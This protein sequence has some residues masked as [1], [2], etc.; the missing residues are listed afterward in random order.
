MRRYLKLQSLNILSGKSLVLEVAQRHGVATN[1]EAYA[2]EIAR[3]SHG[4]PWLI[5]LAVSKLDYM[6]PEAIINELTA[7]QSQDTQA[8][9]NE[10]I[11]VTVEQMTKQYGDKPL[12]LLR[13][14]SVCRG[15]FNAE[16]ALLITDTSN[17]EDL[18][19]HLKK[20]MNYRFLRFDGERYAIDELVSEAVGIDDNARRS[21]YETYLTIAHRW[22]ASKDPEKYLKMDAEWE[23]FNAAFEWVLKV[24]PASAVE[25]ANAC[26]IYLSN[27][28]KWS[29]RQ[30]WFLAL[31]QEMH[32]LD[33]RA[34]ATLHN[35]LGVTY[36]ENPF[37]D[38]RY[39][40]HRA[41]V[42]YN[43]AL[44]YRTPEST[45]LEYASTQNNLGN[46]LANLAEFESE[47]S[48]YLKQAI[49]AF[50]EALLYWTP[51]SDPL[52]HANI[53]NNLGNTY[54][55]LSTIED[56]EI[57]VE[58]AI[59]SYNAALNYFTSEAIPLSRATTQNNLGNTY[60]ILS[61]V[62]DQA[63]N[64]KRSITAYEEALIIRTPENTPFEYAVTQYNLGNV[65]Q[66]LA[67]VEDRTVNF[68]RALT[69][70]EAALL[71]GTMDVAPLQN[72]K[73]KGNLG[74]VLNYLGDLPRAVRYWR[75]AE[76]QFRT[77]GATDDAN[78]L[79]EWIVQ[80]EAVLNENPPPKQ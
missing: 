65:Y 19:I 53:Q 73:T 18:Y 62:R 38:R 70:Y 35:G 56:R 34:K 52:N 8:A 16:S 23:N 5:E 10:I 9:L 26:G 24:D 69:A 48:N 28:G 30:K 54:Q 74:V 40:L 57:N 55:L 47:P 50:D 2:E 31:E 3:A 75:E 44:S 51:E 14:L 17:I 80:G 13:R 64:L 33:P 6:P 68:N 42:E 61:E 1:L 27:R 41:I 4:H 46:A 60:R 12:S 66:I 67:R 20:L 78:R 77:M 29:Q 79:L 71:Y 43:A 11:G 7:L 37:E 58:R 39:N 36:Q 22:E 59:A 15:G 63:D 72:A 45:P 76:Q 25:L 32:N 49:V 21:H